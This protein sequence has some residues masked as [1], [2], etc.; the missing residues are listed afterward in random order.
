M[1]DYRNLI[2]VIYSGHFF[3]TTAMTFFTPSQL[4]VLKTSLI[5]AIFTWGLTLLQLPHKFD[6]PIKLAGLTGV[7]AWEFIIAKRWKDAAIMAIV[8]CLSFGAQYLMDPY[9]PEK[10]TDTWALLTHLNIFTAYLLT[11]ITRFHLIGTE[12]KISAGLLAA[13]IF[14]FLP[15]TGNPFSSGF[16]FTGHLIPAYDIYVAITSLL[17][18][19]FKMISYYVIIFL[20]ENGYKWKTFFSKLPSKVQLFSKWEY[21]F[22]WMT[23]YFAYMGCIGDLST[24]VTVLFEGQRMPAEPTWLSLLFMLSTV[25]FLYAGALMLRNII[26]GRAL[27]TGKYNPWLLLLHLIPGVNIIAVAICF[28]AETREGTLVDNALDYVNANRSLA[29]K[30]MIAIGIIVTVYNIYN[31]L[32]VPT[33]LRLAGIGIL[34]VL[35][36]LKIGAYIKLPS[37][38]TFVYIVMGLNIITIAYSINEH[39]IIYLSLIYLYYYFL[40]ELFYPE[41]EMDDIQDG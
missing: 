13:V 10:N 21:L 24:R 20:V 32:V 17:L 8:I 31:M 22:M 33:G 29:K 40:V 5:L 28:F 39:F 9:L 38:K 19:W 2:K 12:N 23:I 1:I 30:T 41:L 18:I 37:G 34:A 4:R 36:L 25:F 26:T 6:L 27:T 15:K 7:L 16:L 3:K 14:Y 35:Y 11:I